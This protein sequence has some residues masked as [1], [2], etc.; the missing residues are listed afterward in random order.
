[1][2]TDN[3]FAVVKKLQNK[4]E[5]SENNDES[6]EGCDDLYAQTAVTAGVG[7]QD[8]DL[9]VQAVET[10]GNTVGNTDQGND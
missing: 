10:A 6:D 3:G 5:E 4:N 2:N 9:Y 7:D 1:M 8:D